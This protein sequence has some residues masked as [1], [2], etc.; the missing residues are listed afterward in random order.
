VFLCLL[1][2]LLLTGCGGFRCITPSVDDQPAIKAESAFHV[3]PVNYAMEPDPKWDVSDADWA[4]KTAD[5]SNAFCQEV[6]TASRCPVNVLSA[7]S[8]PKD[9][10]L[11]EF[12]VTD[13]SPGTYSYFVNTPGRVWGNVTITDIK[14]GNVLFKGTVDAVGD[15]RSHLEMTFG[16]RVQSA[17]YPVAWDLRDVINRD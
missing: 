17:H 10:A 14:S 2:A 11:V 7:D 3:K 15:T 16:G 8:E 4:N 13:I 6:A 12:T 9:G 5:W 1:I